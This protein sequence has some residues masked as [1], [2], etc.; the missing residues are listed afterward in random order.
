MSYTVT[1]LFEYICMVNLGRS[2]YI[3]NRKF[4][5]IYKKNM[6]LFLVFCLLNYTGDATDVA[7]TERLNKLAAFQKKALEHALSCK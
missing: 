2:V 5:S 7:G 1:L 3:P 6:F 4:Y